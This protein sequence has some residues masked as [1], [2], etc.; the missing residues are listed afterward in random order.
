MH[1]E[2]FSVDIDDPMKAFDKDLPRWEHLRLL[3]EAFFARHSDLSKYL[4]WSVDSVYVWTLPSYF[5]C[6]FLSAGDVSAGHA[7]L[8]F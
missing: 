3:R 8:F 4:L 1:E 2:V 7:L 5:V 6:V